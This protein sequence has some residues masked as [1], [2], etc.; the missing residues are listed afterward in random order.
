MASHEFRTPLAAILSSA[1]LLA[2][3]GER[4]PAAERSEVI[5]L[6][7]GAVKRMNEMVEQVLL[8]G[9]A[10][11]GGLEFNPA[12][13]DARALCGALAEEARRG[14]AK[15]ELTHSG[16]GPVR[17]LDE[18]LLR[19]ILGNLLG[20]AVKYSPRNKGSISLLLACAPDALRFEVADRGIGIPEADL[21]L[22]F[23]RF[24]RGANV[25][26][27]EGTGLGLAIVRECVERHG[28]RIEVASRVGHGST[29]TVH[30]PAAA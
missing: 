14:G 29:F 25:G 20:N 24:H 30:I 9:R 22:L 18:K 16:E 4:L 5:G 19:H 26:G 1:E 15:V 3:H 2:D 10:E 28:G 12:P 27:I 13:V 8:I 21:P 7:K 6:I 11:S 23:E 17:R